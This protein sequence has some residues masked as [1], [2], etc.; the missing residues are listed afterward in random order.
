[1]RTV[2]LLFA[3]T[4]GILF[5]ESYFYGFPLLAS[6]LLSEVLLKAIAGFHVC[7]ALLNMLAITH[8]QMHP[9]VICVQFSS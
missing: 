1:M 2:L 7:T 6:E 5:V 8:V 3:Y 4:C 9:Q